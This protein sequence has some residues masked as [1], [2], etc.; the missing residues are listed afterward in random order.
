[1]RVNE[2]AAIEAEF[3][4][5]VARDICCNLATV[6]EQ[7]RLRS[8]VVHPLWEGLVCWV[9]TDRATPKARHID[10]HP[11]VSLAYIGDNTQP[12]YAEC[13]AEWIEDRVEKRRIWQRFRASPLG[14]DPALFYDRVNHPNL[15]LLKLIPWRI[16][17]D[18]TPGETYIWQPE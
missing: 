11:F 5:R 13:K 14:Y 18:N 15:G 17:I 9:L 10:R 12:A 1:M 8:R 6:D 2:F 4:A 3:Q 7:K 16:Q